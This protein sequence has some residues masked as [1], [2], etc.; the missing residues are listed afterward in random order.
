MSAPGI[1][2]LHGFCSAP[3]SWKARL[4]AERMAERGHA[5]RYYCP[6]LSVEPEEAIAQC[7]ALIAAHA[8]AFPGA[9][10]IDTEGSTKYLDVA[11]TQ[12]PTS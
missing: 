11:R 10:F 7:E 6:A 4:L 5:D 3:A 8:A 9:L 1:L 2:Y 12:R